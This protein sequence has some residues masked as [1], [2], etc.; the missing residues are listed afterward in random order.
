M[1][2]FVILLALLVP[3]WAGSAT[4]QE[5]P[6]PLTPR[7]SEFVADPQ[8]DW[9]G[10]GR[11]TSS[12]EFV[13]FWNPGEEP[14]DL[15]GWTLVVNDTTPN[16]ITLVGVL[17]AHARWILINPAGE[18]NNDGHLLLLDPTG[19]VADEVGYGNWPGNSDGIPNANAAGPLDEAL[20][21]DG[22]AWTRGHATPGAE[23]LAPFFVHR[24]PFPGVRG[25]L[26]ANASRPYPLTASWADSGRAYGGAAVRVEN[27]TGTRVLNATLAETDGR[28]SASLDLAP[29]ASDFS[30][31]WVLADAG[32]GEWLQATF[33]VRVDSEA[34]TVPRLVVPE[35]I[36]ALPFTVLVEGA[37]DAGVGG[38]E[39]RLDSWDAANATWAPMGP[40][41]SATT[42]LVDAV[43]TTEGVRLRAR[44]RDAFGNEAAGPDTIT[45]VDAQPPPAPRD[46][47][48]VGYADVTV[49]WVPV[50]EVEGSGVATL[51]VHRAA[52]SGNR[53]WTLPA[54]ATRV[55][56]SSA[57]LGE[58]LTYEVFAVDHAGNAGPAAR[59]VAD[60]EGIRPHARPLRLNKAI[61][62]GGALEVRADFDR[63]MDVTREPVLET[64]GSTRVD[65]EG[66]WLANRTTYSARIETAEGLPEG[67]LMVRL[68]HAWDAAGRDLWAPAQA[69]VA[70][71]A[72]APVLETSDVDGWVN[73]TGLFLAAWDASDR[74]PNVRH[75]IADAAWTDSR[76]EAW[77]AVADGD[78]VQA[79]A[80]DWAGRQSATLSRT[81]RVDA[82]PPRIGL[83]T[84]DG[85]SPAAPIRIDVYDDGSGVLEEGL[86]VLDAA[87]N[88]LSFELDGTRRAFRL[89]VASPAASLLVLA[90]DR[91]GNA[92][93]ASF[94]IAPIPAPTPIP[95][96]PARD[97]A[98][99][100]AEA[101]HDAFQ[102]LSTSLEVL[103]PMRMPALALVL[104][105][106]LLG[107]V[108]RRRAR[109]PV[110][111]LAARVEKFRAAFEAGAFPALPYAAPST[112]IGPVPVRADDG[113][114]D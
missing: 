73:A 39:T 46:L 89:R 56:D 51:H 30:Y 32:A 19:S 15:A 71:D 74:E 35:W 85:A 45:R 33:A 50:A 88:E 72:S 27:A 112:L 59:I 111:S 44:A 101:R 7:L 52:A 1:R 37:S 102:A 11:V 36:R 55:V 94:E 110:G 79:M 82:S 67:T 18:V 86:R 62:G 69:A 10:D 80:V 8:T 97:E 87:G 91:V 31:A 16:T 54:E 68:S 4:A 13:E 40:W 83:V 23:P 34:P 70:L 28:W 76:R 96:A 104:G 12:D 61:W 93:S 20:R 47:E 84:P 53:S 17:P 107:F 106:F 38:V 58:P 78:R 98:T 41:T 92:A 42:L 43:N 63:A 3:A 77:V 22:T 100:V 14:F 57:R 105:V 66:R 81:L 2:R 90:Q 108:R 24:P 95:G 5:P 9:S 75:R 99:H 114:T 29:P 26:W 113:A 49:R 25:S 65:F 6:R 60:H 64:V 21:W 48:A 103:A 109:L